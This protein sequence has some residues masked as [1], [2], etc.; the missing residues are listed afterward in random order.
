MGKKKTLEERLEGDI[1]TD[2]SKIN[3]YPQCRDC[4]FRGME[5]GEA[6]VKD[7]NRCYCR[8]YSPPESKPHTIYLGTSICEFYEKEK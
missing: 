4:L 5:I 3:S 2:N 8:I 6:W 1:L 7:G